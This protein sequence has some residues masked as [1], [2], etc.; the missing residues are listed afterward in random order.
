MA[1]DIPI[2]GTLIASPVS[3]DS[4]TALQMMTAG[5]KCFIPWTAHLQRDTALLR[6]VNRRFG[7]IGN[8][9]FE[10]KLRLLLI[11]GD[12]GDMDFMGRAIAIFGLGT[13]SFPTASAAFYWAYRRNKSFDGRLRSWNLT[14]KAVYMP[15]SNRY[16]ATCEVKKRNNKGGQPARRGLLGAF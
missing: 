13:D 4:G 7:I 3:D 5:D 10:C 1:I 12:I 6:T 9:I 8:F 15:T 16:G 11:Q 2:P 14:N